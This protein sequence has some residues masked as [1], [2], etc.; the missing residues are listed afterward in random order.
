MDFS[1]VVVFIMFGI[2]V[3]IVMALR[4]RREPVI[5]VAPQAIA[6]ANAPSSS[7]VSPSKWIVLALIGIVAF[8][9]AS[10]FL[11]RGAGIPQEASVPQVESVPQKEVASV[12][13]P[14]AVPV[15]TV[16]I[17]TSV[18]VVISEP[19]PIHQYT[20]ESGITR[21]LAVLLVLAIGVSVM[22]VGATF[23]WRLRGGAVDISP[24]MSAHPET[25]PQP[26]PKRQVILDYAEEVLER[27]KQ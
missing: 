5:H 7:G 27:V 12:P 2:I 8:A 16:T 10:Q 9:L 13:V 24:Q 20:V 15:P 21:I 22:V 1:N 26:E 3:G 11:S 18:P 25:Q 6:T 17:P 19:V 4:L 14:T 23:L